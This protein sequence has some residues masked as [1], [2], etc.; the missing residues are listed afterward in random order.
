MR[1]M[2]LHGP[3]LFYM[4]YIFLPRASSRL[5][6]IRAFRMVWIWYL[7]GSGVL[8]LLYPFRAFS[9]CWMICIS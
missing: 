2:R 5:H 4:S 7:Q 3:Q 6:V 9:F 8:I 1:S